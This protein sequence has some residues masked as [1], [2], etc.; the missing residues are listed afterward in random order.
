M[1]LAKSKKKKNHFSLVWFGYFS[2]SFPTGIHDNLEVT[3]K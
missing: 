3:R 2:I 1:G